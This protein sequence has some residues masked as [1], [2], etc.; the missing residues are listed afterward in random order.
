MRYIFRSK[1]KACERPNFH[2]YRHQIEL[3]LHQRSEEKING[4]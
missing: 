1:V 4:M 2:D 3:N